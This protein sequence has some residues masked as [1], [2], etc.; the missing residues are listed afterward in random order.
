MKSYLGKEGGE[1]FPLF[2]GMRMVIMVHDEGLDEVEDWMNNW[3]GRMGDGGLKM[4]YL[5][6]RYDIV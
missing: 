4:R 3:D 5:K 1:A 2:S 6:L